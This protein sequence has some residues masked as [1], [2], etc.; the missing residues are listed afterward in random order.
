MFNVINKLK[1]LI[2][3]MFEVWKI[4]CVYD[5]ILYE[6]DKVFFNC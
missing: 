5:K 1:V 6:E 4:F 2:E 3:V